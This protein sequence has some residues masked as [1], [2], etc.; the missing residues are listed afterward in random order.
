MKLWIVGQYKGGKR[1]KLRWEFQGI[2]DTKE[3]AIGACRNYKY[4]IGSEILN[5]E[6]PDETRTFPDFE[7]PLARK[8]K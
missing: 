2:F 7:Y 6:V 4:F 8:K 5:Q 1:K 3:R